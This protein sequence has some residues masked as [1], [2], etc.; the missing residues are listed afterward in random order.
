[1][2]RKLHLFAVILSI[3]VFFSCGK[4]KPTQ[5][6]KPDEPGNDK[7]EWSITVASLDFE[8]A[9]GTM[10]IEIK[11][12]A[13]KAMD[14]NQVVVA[15]AENG[16]D[17][18]DAAISDGKVSVT[19]VQNYNT[20]VR[21]T[22]LTVTYD[23]EKRT[24]TVNQKAGEGLTDKKIT[25]LS[26]TGTSEETSAEQR[27]F[28]HSHD[29]THDTWFNSRFGEITEWPFFLEYTL[30]TPN[31]LNY[32]MY[33]PRSDNGT[34][35]GAFNKFDVYV[36]T[37]AN[38]DRVKVASMER[39]NTNY[40]PCKIALDEAVEN[41]ETVYFEIH[42]AHNNRVSCAEMEFHET[43]G[44]WFDY[45]TIFA[46][47]VCSTLKA[48]VTSAQIRA[49]PDKAYRDVATALLEGTYNG[50]FRVAEFR[51]YQTP[52]IM[53][54]SN[55]IP[56]SYSKND[57]PT[58]IYVD[59]G[60][61]FFV[62]V[63]KLNGGEVSLVI[64]NLEIGFGA[65][66]TLHIEEGRNKLT[67]P[68]SGLLYVMN[69][70][71]DAIPLILETDAEKAAAAA[72]TARMHFVGGKVQGY[73]RKGATTDEQWTRMISE[74]P[75]REIDIVGDYAHLT[76]LASQFKAAPQ[77]V[78]RQIDSL[79]RLVFLQQKL[80][81]L[82][83][84]NK[85]FRNR[86]YFI[87]LTG[88]NPN[89]SMYRT[90]YTSGYGEIFTTPERFQARIWVLG[91]EVGHINQLYGMRWA[92]MTEV[93]N[94]IYSLFVQQQQTPNRRLSTSES[95]SWNG[96]SYPN[97]YEAA[98]AAIVTPGS[99]HCLDNASN[100]FVLKVVPFWQLHLYLVDARGKSDF[101]ADLFE[102][103]RTCTPAPN[104]LSH[105]AQQLLFV[106]KAC[107]VAGMDL[108]DF[109]E[110]WGFLTPVDKTLS[111]YGSKQLTITQAD[112]DATK[113]RIAACGYPKPPHTADKI[114]A[115]RDANV[116][117]YKN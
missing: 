96:L 38:P 54:A 82:E 111:D 50:A 25:V 31:R 106:E 107:E 72:K 67:A 108:V 22:A 56:Y 73:Y 30:Q 13:G 87:H 59:E 116:N 47:D 15:I 42:T 24:V 104:S 35:Y 12:T 41:V 90:A 74:A 69:Q 102:Y 2:K 98:I 49:I 101:W 36:T 23:D 76:W 112:V 91:H 109:F 55:R 113:V 64:Q 48:G 8:A 46:D 86:M 75:Y 7:T 44:S 51:P 4:D 100:E 19:T 110:K 33:Y 85:M 70:T 43:A 9:G 92:G 11:V 89:A 77:Y 62:H 6:D 10:P 14:M 61:E 103:Y 28:S 57:N 65:P 68:I 39:G 66:Q 32:I 18:A 17:W 16:I 20:T 114:I 95:A 93:S 94:N 40:T 78:A 60:D 5:P 21:T 26:A 79:D 80:A 58:G 115:I 117:D 52:T 29:G 105:G 71:S 1:M 27:L 53:A 81:G 45:S 97:V 88:G 83:K 37:K 3:C 34:K 63:G 99:P 84:Y